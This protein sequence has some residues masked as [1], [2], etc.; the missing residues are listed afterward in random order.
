MRLNKVMKHDDDPVRGSL[1]FTLAPIQTTSLRD[2]VHER[3]RLAIVSGY[4]KAGTRLNERK[5][6]AEMGVSTSPVKEG[7]RRLEAEGLV[8]TE[9]RRG[10]FVTFEA[11]QAEEMTLARAALESLVAG[12]AAQHATQDDLERM[13]ALLGRMKAA[14]EGDD[15][16]HLVSLN[17]AFHDAVRAAS[18]GTYLL[19]LLNTLHA[20]N[21]GTRVAVL[22]DR[23][24]R[25]ASLR[26]H[27]AIYEAIAGR[28]VARAEALM[29][30]HV[31]DAGKTHIELLFQADRESTGAHT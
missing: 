6:A 4:Y 28:D 22:S 8:R 23:R 20:F 9:P 15:V 14:L 30:S 5:L 29:R 10:S 1:T 2:E 17:S 26:E 12:M 21:H 24:V 18:G 31:T 7:L 3:L 19:G 16:D 11:R 13:R 27:T 25:K